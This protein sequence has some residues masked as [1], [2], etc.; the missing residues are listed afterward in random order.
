[1]NKGP[2]S[3]ISDVGTGRI[4]I[5]G[6]ITALP[7]IPTRSLEN[8]NFLVFSISE[9]VFSDAIHFR[10]TRLHSSASSKQRALK[11]KPI[12]HTTPV[13]RVKLFI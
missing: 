13:R 5:N 11:I 12:S 6:A 3:A 2:N 10:A 7:T 8:Q 1:M 4:N 9:T